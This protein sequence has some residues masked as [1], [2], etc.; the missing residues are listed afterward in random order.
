[1][2]SHLEKTSLN[3]SAFRLCHQLPWYINWRPDPQSIAKGAAEQVWNYQFLYAFPPFSLIGRVLKKVKKDQTNMI[4]VTPAWQS[5]L[6][7]PILLK[8]TIKNSILLRDYP[9]VLLR[10]EKKIHPLIQNVSL[11]LVARLVSAKFTFKRDIRK[12][13]RPYLK[14][15]KNRVSLK[16]RISLEKKV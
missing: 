7:Y 13:C 11:K 4:I 8:M 15:P 12:W 9:N 2:L 10:P 16:L 5:Q 3:L 1:M 6:W 14:C